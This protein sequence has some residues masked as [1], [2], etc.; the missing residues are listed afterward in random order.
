MTTV[1]R[2]SSLH[3][4]NGLQLPGFRT[5]PSRPLPCR[6]KGNTEIG[7]ERKKRVRKATVSSFR[8]IHPLSCAGFPPSREF[9][10]SQRRASCLTLLAAPAF[11][12]VRNA[13]TLTSGSRTILEQSGN[14]SGG[15]LSFQQ[16]DF[17]PPTGSM[18][19]FVFCANL[20]RLP[21]LTFNNI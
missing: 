12:Y 9:L 19:L 15:L 11:R 8:K 20:E 7:F 4:I 5:G 10:I 14:N 13:Q 16:P 6:R 3:A 1:P 2:P 21:T 18:L 17:R